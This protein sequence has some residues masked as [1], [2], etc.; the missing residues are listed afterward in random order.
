MPIHLMSIAIFL[1]S[2]L[3][4]LAGALAFSL[5]QTPTP[6]MRSRRHARFAHR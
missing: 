4:V 6:R 1:I 3:F 5:R 2:T